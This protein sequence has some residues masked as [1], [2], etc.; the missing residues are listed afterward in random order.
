M[1]GGEEKA[2]VLQPRRD[3]AEL[4]QLDRVQN[5]VRCG[6]YLRE[7]CFESRLEADK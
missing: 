4:L 2:R 5:S 6:P 1:G 7:R 3:L